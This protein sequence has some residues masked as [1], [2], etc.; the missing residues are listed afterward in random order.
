MKANKPLAAIV[1]VAA[2]LVGVVAY[3]AHAAGTQVR[4]ATEAGERLVGKIEAHQRANGAPPPSLSAVG[5]EE[6]GG[7][8]RHESYRV[9]YVAGEGGYC[10]RLVVDDATTLRYSSL[11][12]TWE[13]D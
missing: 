12:G 9:L 8:G 6:E 13:E 3:M 4:R 7:L 10:L 1:T 5:V 2:I 11:N